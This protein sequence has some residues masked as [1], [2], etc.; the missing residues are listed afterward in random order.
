MVYYFLDIADQYAVFSLE[1]SKLH[2]QGQHQDT[3]LHQQWQQDT[4]LHQHQQDVKLHQG[5]GVKL[6]QGHDVKLHQGQDVKLHQGHDV[7]LHQGQDVKLHQGQ[8]DTQLHLQQQDIQLQHQGQDIKLHHQ[9]QEVQAMVPYWQFW[10]HIGDLPFHMFI[11]MLAVPYLHIF[12]ALFYCTLP[13][14]DRNAKKC[15]IPVIGWIYIYQ[16]I[17]SI[18]KTQD[19]TWDRTPTISIS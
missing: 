12:A 16:K 2:H 10:R 9:G 19:G 7:K 15:L 3:Q 14:V 4:Q 5:Q 11:V 18:C 1:H 8:Q 13:S 17:I 6:H